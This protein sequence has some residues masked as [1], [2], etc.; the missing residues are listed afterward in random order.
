MHVGEDVVVESGETVPASIVMVDGD[1]EISGE[2]NGDVVMVGGSLRLAEGG[3][4]TGEVR[5]VNGRVFRDGGEV[6]GDVDTVRLDPGAQVD[7]ERIRAELRNEL[8]GELRIQVRNELGAGR[9]IGRAIGELMGSLLTVLLVGVLGGGLAVHFARDNLQVVADTARRAPMRAGLVGRAGAFLT[10][11]AWILGALGLI[12]SIV[13]ILAL[14]F[15]IVLF[16]IAVCFAARE[17][18]T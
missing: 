14:P 16:P 18:R 9:G 8:Q 3:L 17:Q 13:C 10:L 6:I 5:V 2:V 12:V 7:R 1:L 11:P 15:W 4:V